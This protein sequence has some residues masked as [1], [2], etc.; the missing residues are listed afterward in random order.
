MGVSFSFSEI[1]WVVSGFPFSYYFLF[2]FFSNPEILSR[3]RSLVF[4]GVGYFLLK[5][6]RHFSSSLVLFVSCSLPWCRE[7]PLHW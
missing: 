7:K 3:G 6:V 5:S 1:Q 2:P 4:W